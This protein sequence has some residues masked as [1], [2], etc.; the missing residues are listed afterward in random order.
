MINLCDSV[1]KMIRAVATVLLLAV[2]FPVVSADR[3][4]LLLS[5]GSEL[6]DQIH[7]ELESFLVGNRD[8]VR[9]RGRS[10]RWKACGWCQSEPVPSSPT[11][12]LLHPC[13]YAFCSQ[14]ANELASFP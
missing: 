9:S 10:T 1:T 6:A 12:Q 11:M 14:H 8:L 7:G 5:D 4:Y 3:G 2:S 13:E